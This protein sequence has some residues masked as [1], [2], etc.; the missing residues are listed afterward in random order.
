MA[1][2]KK[3]NKGKNPSPKTSA[4]KSN[5]K[6]LW[7]IFLLSFLLYANTI[8]HEYAFDDS[9][10]ITEN[11]YTQKGFAGIPALMSKD[12]FAGIYGQGL[13]IGGGR[14]RPLSLV[15]FAIEYQLMGGEKPHVSHLINVVLFGL[16]MVFL[17]QML[18][19]VFKGKQLLA[20][21]ITLLFTVHPLHTEVVANIKSR[22]EIL[23]FLFFVL[24]TW[25][26]VGYLDGNRSAKKHL[27]QALIFY[28]LSLL[29]K[30]NGITLL[31]TFPLIL[32]FFRGER[33]AP[34]I[35]ASLP[36]WIVAI[37]YVVIR[38]ALVGFLGDKAS[39]DIMENHFY[40][41]S[42]MDRTATVFVILFKYLTLQFFPHPLSSDYSFNQIPLVGW[43]NIP[44]ILSL[45]IHSIALI[46]SLRIMTKPDMSRIAALFA[47]GFLFYFA[48]IILFSNLV[49]N[50]GAPMGDRF[51]YLP[52]LGSC[53]IIAGIIFFI[54]KTDVE[55]D[56]PQYKKIILPVLIVMIPFSIKTFMRN[57]EWEDNI[58][59]FSADVNNAPNSAKVHY[60]LGNS[61][62]T[63]VLTDKTRPER[64]D[65]LLKS[66]SEFH[67]AVA[68]NPK[69]H[70]AWYD[71]GLIYKELKQPDSA[72]YV[73]EKAIAN[74]P[75]NINMDKKQKGK[76]KTMDKTAVNAMSVLGTVYGEQKNDAVN[77]LKYLEMTATYNPNDIANLANLGIA[78]AMNGRFQDAIATFNKVLAADPN[79]KQAYQNLAG[80]YYQMGDTLRAKQMM[81]Q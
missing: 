2:E 15:T 7:F 79:N 27:W 37:S 52:S 59:L 51:A 18:V 22:D 74:A 64:D 21:A 60:Y 20:L 36:L 66:K 62:L 71:L 32:I 39:P 67:K 9:V 16:S 75:E 1:K 57:A 73:L 65:Y 53:F 50:I 35:R 30:E 68:I 23:A 70:T 13:D 17:F 10:V 54:T 34:A 28:T 38:G 44:A 47:F 76:V 25:K 78:Y 40:G 58:T 5:R 11:Q 46:F 45:L 14:W 42:F 61:M 8:G 24:A 49:F 12:L 77:A 63:E 41:A 6:F 3:K 4:P 81:G 48:S 69:F 19:S 55:N 72:I 56:L 33:L 31:A 26:F 80:V 29:S 43:G